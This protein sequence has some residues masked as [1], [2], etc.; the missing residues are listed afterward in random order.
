MRKYEEIFTKDK[1]INLNSRH[2]RSIV[3]NSYS[4][5]VIIPVMVDKIF[6][7]IYDNRE[8]VSGDTIGKV[9]YCF[10]ILGY[11]PVVTDATEHILFDDFAEAIHR[12][13]EFM[14][15]VMITK[16]CLALCFFRALPHSLIER[17][18]HI[19]FITRL[20]DEIRLCYSKVI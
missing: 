15:A 7:Y 16:S 17:V 9:L 20:E 5:N 3:Y 10:Y 19:D 2:I 11:E 1:D 4:S 12:D 6:E 13:F 14:S 18:F 8:Y